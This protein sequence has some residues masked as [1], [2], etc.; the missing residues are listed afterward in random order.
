MLVACPLH[1]LPPSP[2]RS[3]ARVSCQVL[4]DMNNASMQ[5][6]YLDHNA[7]TPMLPEAAN[8]MARCAA[9]VYANPASQHVPGRAA[10]RTLETARSSIAAML[11]A[12]LTAR[13]PDRLILTSGG[14]E[15]NNAAVWGIA[16][17]AGRNTAIP[18]SPGH[19]IV[20]AIEHPCVA[21]AAERL[22]ETGWDIDTLGVD[23]QGTVCAERL[24]KLLREQT[25]LLS[26]IL[27]NHE[28]GVIQPIGQLAVECRRR[29]VWMHTD[30]VQAAG[31][32][33]VN[34]RSLGVSAMS[35]AAHKFGGPAGIGALL[36]APGVPVE[37]WFVGGSQ[38]EGLR[39]G[40]EPVV[41]AVGMEEA[42]RQ[43]LDRQAEEQRRLAA[44]RDR[45]EATVRAARP[46]VVVH[47]VGAERLAQTSS[48]GFPGVEAQVL[49]TVLDMAGVACSIGAACSSG[50]VEPSATLMAN[51]AS[52]SL[53]G[54]SLR[55]SFGHTSTDDD[56]DRAAETLVACYARV[57]ATSESA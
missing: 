17:A 55:F 29:G 39:P 18:G 57:A 48:L 44:L 38:Q 13:P 49:F 53:A 27:A 32:L 56:A 22:L 51:E 5:T 12:D 47:G 30:A 25:R 19:A 20:S 50:A 24:P 26:V 1:R 2:P 31:K 9:E 54:S 10:Q 16:R 33:P 42:L 52:R 37:P 21:Q 14:T 11:G 34:F 40:T 28:T 6:I 23:D 3:G 41:L 45:F 7:T 43:T 4:A 8:A 46:E 35:I 15:S 36:L